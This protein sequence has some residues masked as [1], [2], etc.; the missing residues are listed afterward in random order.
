MGNPSGLARTSP[1]AEAISPPT[2]VSAA[3]FRRNARR[4]R[5]LTSENQLEAELSLPG[6]ARRR[7]LAEA[8]RRCERGDPRSSRGAASVE[9]G[10]RRAQARVHADEIRG[11]EHVED[12]ESQLRL[13]PAIEFD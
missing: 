1:T 10:A 6:I 12:F 4:D 8:A 13:H 2:T 7:G 9:C 3:A 11:V 5:S